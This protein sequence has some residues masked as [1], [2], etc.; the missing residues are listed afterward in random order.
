[1]A[2][3]LIE[4]DRAC[5]WHPFTQMQTTL[6]PIS[7]VRAKGVYLYSEEKS[8]IDGISSWWVNL[9]GHAHPYIIEKINAQAESFRACAF[10]PIS[11]MLQL[12]NWPH[13]YSHGCQGTCRK[14]SIQ[15]MDPL[16]SKPP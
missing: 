9:H 10:L 7:I 2:T 5:I 16:L 4:K 11:H 15:I 13:G 14:F 3:T 6:S 8:Y 12:L 1:M